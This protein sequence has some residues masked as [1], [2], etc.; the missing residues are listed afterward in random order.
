MCVCASSTS[1]R[2]ILV[3]FNIGL[4]DEEVDDSVQSK[5]G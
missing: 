5:T 4:K 1:E 2:Y 3:D